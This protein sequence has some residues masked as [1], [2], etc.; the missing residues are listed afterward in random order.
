VRVWDP[1]PGGQLAVLEGHQG[2]VRAVCAVTISDRPLL[3]SG[4]DRTVRL[5][6]PMTGTCKLTVPTHHQT[7]AVAG[8]AGSLAIGL[9]EGILVIKLSSTD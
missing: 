1:L 9:D 4:G 8:I 2:Q 7:L 3:A 5:W 6:D